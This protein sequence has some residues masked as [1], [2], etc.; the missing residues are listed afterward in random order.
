MTIETQPSAAYQALKTYQ[1]Q[2]EYI[3]SLTDTIRKIRDYSKETLEKEGIT[4]DGKVDA[5][6]LW[7]HTNSLA[8]KHLKEQNFDPKDVRWKLLFPIVKN[9]VKQFGSKGL[10]QDLMEQII[11]AYLRGSTEY[12]DERVQ[13]TYA[14]LPTKTGQKYLKPIAAV[15]GLDGIY[16]ND[17]AGTTDPQEVAGLAAQFG[18]ELRG[19][20]ATATA[21]GQ[22]GKLEELVKAQEAQ[23]DKAA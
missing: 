14:Q 8:E 2:N 1:A 16:D 12:A 19:R 4:K 23:M 22:I 6:S 10:T 20:V 7:L 3:R 17:I 13:G 11:G 15:S 21:K 5:E 18:A 9:A